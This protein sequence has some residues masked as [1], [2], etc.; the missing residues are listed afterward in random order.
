MKQKIDQRMAA[1]HELAGEW[2]NPY[3]T[4]TFKSEADPHVGLT[5]DEYLISYQEQKTLGKALNRITGDDGDGDDGDGD[6]GDGDD[7]DQEESY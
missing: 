3:H 5:H 4:S 2:F 1:Q 6:D 7:G